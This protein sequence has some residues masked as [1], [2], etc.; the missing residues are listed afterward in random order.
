M[1]DQIEKSAI[2]LS[3]PPG[4]EAEGNRAEGSQP[5]ISGP[6]TPFEHVEDKQTTIADPTGRIEQARNDYTTL[7]NILGPLTSKQAE[8]HLEL[9]SARE[10]LAKQGS[11]KTN[12]ISVNV[13]DTRG[14]PHFSS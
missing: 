11:N 6:L 1:S 4:L 12:S 2:P 3:F 10:D 8:L 13:V 9:Q 5:L 14:I 7:Q